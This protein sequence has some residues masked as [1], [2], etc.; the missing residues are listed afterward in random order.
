MLSE[1]VDS[2]N[3]GGIRVYP[4]RSHILLCGG[5]VA[6]I[7]HSPTSLRDVYLRHA[8]SCDDISGEII[9]IEEITEFFDKDSPYIDL[10]D[11]ERD[12]AQLSELV[13]LFSESPGSFAELGSFSSY[14]EI[15]EKTL[16]I[17][18]NKFDNKPGFVAK[19]PLAK[20][21]RHNTNSVFTISDSEFGIK[22]DVVCEVDGE[23]LYAKIL[24]PVNKRL[25]DVKERTTLDFTRFNHRAKIYIGILQEFVVLKDSEILDFFA[26]IGYPIE[27]KA[28][29]RI[30]FCCSAF[31]WSKCCQD[32]FDRIHF[33]LA[34]KE[35]VS[36]DFKNQ[37]E[38]KTRRRMMRLAHWKSADPGRVAAWQDARLP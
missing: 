16:V 2:L 21:R 4:P 18:R 20:L 31:R 12:I 35:A 3:S 36:W 27:I 6:S 34:D 22:N 37:Q 23:K 33:S 19:G 7:S 15:F 8:V 14:S 10:V 1:F 30:A 24:E 32:G 11:F 17:I 38:D 25:N 26:K 28:L 9:Q 29:D 5:A 13:L